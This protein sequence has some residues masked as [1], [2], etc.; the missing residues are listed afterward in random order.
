MADVDDVRA[1]TLRYM[2]MHG[3]TLEDI[4]ARARLGTHQVRDFLSGRTTPEPVVQALCDRLDLSLVYHR[5][6][7]IRRK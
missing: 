3:L 6:V 4:A 7:I 2:D 5:R 1:M